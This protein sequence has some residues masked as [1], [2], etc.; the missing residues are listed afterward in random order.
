[1]AD[2]VNM[3]VPR[4]DQNLE[5]GEQI[6]RMMVWPVD[7]ATGRAEP[8]KIIT[9]KSKETG[10]DI[11]TEV[12]RIPLFRWRHTIATIDSWQLS[13]T[14]KGI[15]EAM[16]PHWKV[17]A[18]VKE[19]GQYG[20]PNEESESYLAPMTT[21][22]G[23]SDERLKKITTNDRTIMEGD[24]PYRVD[25]FRGAFGYDKS[26]GKS[27]PLNEGN[28]QALIK[29]FRIQSTNKDTVGIKGDGGY[30]KRLW[31]P[32]SEGWNTREVKEIEEYESNLAILKSWIGKLVYWEF[33]EYDPTP[34]Q[35]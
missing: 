25:V 26:T 24:I 9:T 18:D 32:F 6:T 21:T 23:M 12:S 34:I 10:K 1:M 13:A 8:A 7:P 3:L 11:R 29:V 33:E 20:D 35:R 28:V 14:W 19:P 22:T 15:R 31:T 27:L 30:L 2:K 17:V 5:V 16:W 4:R